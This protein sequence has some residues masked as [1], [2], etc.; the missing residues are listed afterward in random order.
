MTQSDATVAT[1]DAL[2]S[3][4]APTIL[5]RVGWWV[6]V[7]LTAV[8]V[9]NH[10]LGVLAYATSDDERALF[11]IFLAFNVLTLVVLL[12]PYR[13]RERWSWWATWIPVATNA[14]PLV[15]F[16]I[17]EVVVFYAAGAAVMAAAQLTTL[18]AFD[19]HHTP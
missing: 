9:A 14:L 19:P 10:A 11:A 1:P 5:F 13:R 7:V 3:R 15:L 2:A 17:D 6:L 16:S 4:R 8:L 18:P 12:I